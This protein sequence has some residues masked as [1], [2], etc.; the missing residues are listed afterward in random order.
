MQTYENIIKWDEKGGVFGA[1]P[2]S[3]K[4]LDLEDKEGN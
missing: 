1:V 3:A 2:R 4:Y